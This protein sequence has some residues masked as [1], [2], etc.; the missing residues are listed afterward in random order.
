MCTYVF[1]GQIFTGIIHYLTFHMD[2][3]RSSV[4]DNHRLPSHAYSSHGH[5]S[6]LTFVLLCTWFYIHD[7]GSVSFGLYN[8]WMAFVITCKIIT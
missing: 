1:I 3:I 5:I 8:F 2:T 7:A 4:L 6:L